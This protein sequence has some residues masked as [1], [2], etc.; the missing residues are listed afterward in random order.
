M[1]HLRSASIQ[2]LICSLISV[3]LWSCSSVQFN[4]TKPVGK[5]T[6]AVTNDIRL[7]Q[8]WVSDTLAKS[9]SAF[10]K[11]N[12]FTPV[13]YNNQIITANGYD[14]L[15]S[16]NKSNMQI[17]W[18]FKINQGIE[19]SGLVAGGQLFVGGLDGLFYSIDLDHGKLNWKF[20]T[21]TEIVSEPLLHKGII[22]FLNGAN[23]LFS[24]DASSGK[25]FWVYNRQETSTQ[26]TIR[27][28]SRPVID[29]NLIYIGFSDGS[30]AAINISSGNPQWEVLLNKNN[31]F[32]DID[33][34]PVTDGDKTYINSYD[35]KLYC[36]S[37]AN[38]TIIWKSDFGGAS[39]PLVSGDRLVYSTSKSHIM[40][41]SKSDGKL[42]WSDKNIL[43]VATEPILHKGFVIVGESQ[44]SLKL[45]DLLTGKLKASFEPGRGV[46]S[47]P[48]VDQEQNIYFISGEANIYGVKIQPVRKAE[49][50]YLVQ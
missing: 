7:K 23:A 27:G 2:I 19:S 47:K 34:S 5:S 18:R 14:G 20:D 30:L 45:F 43:G 10:R 16:Y 21:K 48:V 42:I 35:D 3:L 12:R 31:R 15:V 49:I 26:M 46:F 25:Q 38:G 50:P 22:Y 9:N 29:N 28:G 37:K 1:I 39:A 4:E 11:I 6:D 13:F 44:G 33:S 41:V 17:N 8:F 40:S 24:L 36:L 32:K